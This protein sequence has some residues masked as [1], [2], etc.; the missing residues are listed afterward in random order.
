MR[1]WRTLVSAFPFSPFLPY[2]VER[3]QG[4]A[5]D[6]Y[7]FGICQFESDQAHLRVAVLSQ[8]DSNEIQLKEHT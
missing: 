6:G 8:G 3:P 4:C 1:A 2:E 5:E 7:F